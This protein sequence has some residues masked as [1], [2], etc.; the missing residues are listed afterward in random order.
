MFPHFGG[1]ASFDCHAHDPQEEVGMPRRDPPEF[2]RKVL[3]LIEAGRAGAEVAADLRVSG[4]TMDLID[5]G[6][7][8]ARAGRSLRSWGRPSAGSRGWRLSSPRPSRP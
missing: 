2:R 4:Q 3:D 5:P 1:V 8:P 6:D 7:G